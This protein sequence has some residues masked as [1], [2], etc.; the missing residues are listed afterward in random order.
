MLKSMAKI[1][2][3]HVPYKGVAPA[4]TDVIGGQVE[5]LFVVAQAGLPHVKSGK[6]RGLAVASGRRFAATPEL[7]TLAESGLP[8]FAFDAW[9]GVHMPARTPARIVAK[10]NAEFARIVRLP[11]MQERMLNSLGAESV[12]GT[13]AEFGAFV[14]NEIAMWAKVIREAGVRAE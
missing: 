6:L 11:D 7:P 10:L 2:L 13:A 4:L 8:D 3:V 14:R 12:G 9:N 5:M 1:D